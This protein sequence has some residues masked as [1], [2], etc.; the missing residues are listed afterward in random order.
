MNNATAEHNKDGSCKGTGSADTKDLPTPL[1]EA[2]WSRVFIPNATLSDALE[3]ARAA[4]AELTQQLASAQEAPGQ[5]G[6]SGSPS[7]ASKSHV[8]QGIAYT[9]SG[10]K[11]IVQI[12][13][14][15]V[16]SP[17]ATSSLES[18]TASDD[19]NATT[20]VGGVNSPLIDSSHERI[21]LE[22]VYELRLWQVIALESSSECP[23][24]GEVP[25]DTQSS[26][27]ARKRESDETAND[28]DSSQA[29][30]NSDASK[31]A[32]G[33]DSNGGVL[34]REIRWL[35]GS[36]CAEIV[37]ERLR[38]GEE[39][40]ATVRERAEDDGTNKDNGAKPIPQRCWC[41]ENKYLQHGADISGKEKLDETDIMRSVEVFV[42]EPEFGNTVFADELMTGRWRKKVGR[43][44]IGTSAAA[45]QLAATGREN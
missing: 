37:V 22:T 29:A 38:E 42:E 2:K 39:H 30:N 33:R 1:R 15:S 28:S 18:G 21:P 4:A 3:R 11:A 34:A 20:A 23:Q 43:K 32:N 31:S 36:G 12:D 13:G 44:M 25:N 17:E 14:T 9:T 26:G 35:N 5:G 45:Q 8:L 10:A 41:R 24:S 40:E 6:E 16:G 7:Q 27:S 19:H